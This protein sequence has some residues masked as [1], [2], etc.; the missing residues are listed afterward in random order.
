M[1]KKPIA[2]LMFFLMAGC[3]AGFTASAE[4]IP[5]EDLLKRIQKL[6]ESRQ[7]LPDGWMKRVSI[8]GALEAE[9]GFTST[10]FADPAL[11]DTDESDAALS[12]MALDMDA[13]IN[14]HVSGHILF[15]WEEDGTG[16]VDLDEGVITVHGGDAS[17]FYLSAGKMYVP[18]GHFESHM[19][20][21]PLTHELAETR[22]SAIQAGVDSEGVYGSV[23]AFNGDMDEDGKDNN[24][25]NFGGNAG[26]IMEKDD[27]CLDIG[28]C[29]INNIL[30]SDGGFDIFAQKAETAEALGVSSALRGYVPGAG[31][32]AVV[33]CGPVSLIG[34]Y[35]A[36]LEKPEWNITDAVP[37]SMA[38]LNLDAVEKGG[39]YAAYHLELGCTRS[40]CG[41]TTT[42][43]V[44]AQGTGDMENFLPERRFLGSVGVCIFRQTTLALEYCHDKYDND[45]EADVVTT[46]LAVAF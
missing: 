2:I 28:C 44:G 32:H 19:I 11:K 38:A 16:P 42:F 43:A 6:E 3:I 13:E 1:M 34:E 10:D 45:D 30:D 20:S 14:N 17:P 26:V 29:W 4:E 5:Q 39:K 40:I 36:A 41:R 25:D 22:E 18:F 12:T 23:Y 35:I 24:I 27:F 9:A 31:A 21:D 33:S 8:S 15:L 7:V 46:R 37:G